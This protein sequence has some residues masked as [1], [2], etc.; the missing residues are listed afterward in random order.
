MSSSR[1]LVASITQGI[2][3]AFL[4][5]ACLL[6]LWQRTKEKSAPAV[7]WLWIG[8]TVFVNVA[9]LVR[10]SLTFTWAGTLVA[11]LMGPIGLVTHLSLCDRSKRTEKPGVRRL[12]RTTWLILLIAMS[13]SVLEYLI[14]VIPTAGGVDFFFYVLWARDRILGDVQGQI[15]QYVYSPGAY[16]F[17]GWVWRVAGNDLQVYQ[18]V[19]VAVMTL[20]AALSGAVVWR[21]TRRRAA[22][23]ATFFVALAAFSR[24][25][26]TEG[27]S[28]PLILIVVLTGLLVWGG[29]GSVGQL[30]VV[31]P[32]A[33]GLAFGVAIK[34]QGILL[35]GGWAGVAAS[36][37]WRGVALGRVLR[38]GVFFGLLTAG[39]G[40]GL[41]LLEGEGLLPLREAARFV[42]EYESHGSFAS[43]V[44]NAWGE[45]F[46]LVIMA[47]ILS[48]LF[49]ARRDFQND[50]AARVVAFCLAGAVATALQFTKRGYLHY[51][52]LTAGL[53]AVATGISGTMLW[54]RWQGCGIRKG[55]TAWVAM[56]FLTGVV[57]L[58]SADRSAAWI[59]L[60]PN[61]TRYL[62]LRFGIDQQRQL[63]LAALAGEISAGSSLLVLPTQSNYVH[64]FLGTVPRMRALRYAFPPKVG[65]FAT[66]TESAETTQ[67][68]LCPEVA[69]QENDPF[70]GSGGCQALFKRLPDL[71]YHRVARSGGFEVYRRRAQMVIHETPPPRRHSP[72]E[73]CV[74]SGAT[75]PEKLSL[76]R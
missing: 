33:V 39:L 47:V 15:A 19:I 67:V 7:A 55:L 32:L 54:H 11:A 66:L 59:P 9:F 16:T 14:W 73:G 28:E 44:R 22:A 57:S 51:G 5:H 21:L 45:G 70:C 71:G 38:E 27:T 13:I 23:I 60:R 36:D 43:L 68:V 4:L 41:F 58:T 6:V 31:A 8:W 69:R 37:L 29:G 12:M 25:E 64:F 63:S 56:S 61:I 17:W 50:S 48:A 52:L 1:E 35:L 76:L 49:L 72:I 2:S 18:V 74:K 26:G 40:L 62:P 30:L 65:E 46:W 20:A 3:A 75:R 34:Q 53:L 42:V 24:L 10:E